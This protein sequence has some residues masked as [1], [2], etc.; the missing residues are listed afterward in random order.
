MSFSNN[1]FGLANPQTCRCR[2][3]GYI[4]GHSQLYVSVSMPSN[5]GVN[6]N[7]ALCLAFEGVLYYEGPMWWQGADIRIGTRD[8]QLEILKRVNK[9]DFESTGDNDEYALQKYRLF[10]LDGPDA[11][12]RIVAMMAFKAMRCPE[13]WKESTDIPFEAIDLTPPLPVP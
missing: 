8:E 1:I 10:I 6:A 13:I 2:V 5:I 9:S 3:L 4:M 11:Q 12:V 7:E